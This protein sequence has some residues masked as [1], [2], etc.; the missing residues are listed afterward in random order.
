[1]AIPLILSAVLPL[2]LLPSGPHSVLAA[3]VNIAAWLVFVIDY[4]VHERA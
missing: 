3:I 4:V 1:M 2:V